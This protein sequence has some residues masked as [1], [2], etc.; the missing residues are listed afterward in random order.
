MITPSGRFQPSTPLC[1]SISDFHPKTFN[2]AWEVSTILIGLLSFMTSEETTMG[3]IGASERERK[4]LAQ[5]SRWWNSTGGGSAV[6]LSNGSIVHAAA[7]MPDWKAELGDAGEWF[8]SEWPGD[9]FENWMWINRN[10]IDVLSGCI[11]VAAEVEEQAVV[12]ERAAPAAGI[13]AS[14]GPGPGAARGEGWLKRHRL[15]V[16]LVVMVGYVLLSR[17]I[18]SGMATWRWS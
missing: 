15:V 6:R 11:P 16:G 10:K 18:E 13:L 3:S 7:M 8:R 12:R 1:L 17:A 4:L 5:N 2:P 14:G 9:D